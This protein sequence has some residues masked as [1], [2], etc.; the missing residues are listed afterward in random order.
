VENRAILDRIDALAAENARIAANA[1]VTT[2][3]IS[4]LLDLQDALES[5]GRVDVTALG[6]D[7]SGR[8]VSLSGSV[9]RGAETRIRKLSERLGRAG[10][11]PAGGSHTSPRQARRSR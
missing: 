10:L 5:V 2:K 7:Q 11:S 9:P 8:K 4:R 3:E 1:A 6:V